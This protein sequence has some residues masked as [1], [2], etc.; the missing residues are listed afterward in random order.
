MNNSLTSGGLKVKFQNLIK[1]LDFSV[2]GTKRDISLKQRRD[3]LSSIGEQID[4]SP[5]FEHA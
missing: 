1:T 2:S 3:R 4:I 5:T